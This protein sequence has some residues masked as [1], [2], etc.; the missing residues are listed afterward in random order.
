M[1][2]FSAQHYAMVGWSMSATERLAESE[3]WLQY[4]REDLKLASV[5]LE[6]SD[7][8]PRH[9]CNLSQQAAEKAL[10][11]ALVLLGIEFL[12]RHDLEYLNSLLPVDWQLNADRVDLEQLST[13]AVEARYPGDWTPPTEDD[14]RE[15]VEQA[16]AILTAIERSIETEN[17]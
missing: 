17:T 8:T 12:Y 7:V 14:A 16:Q 5:G 10:K 2:A 3:R 15:A 6:N 13:W 1:A 11:A 9:C 4:A